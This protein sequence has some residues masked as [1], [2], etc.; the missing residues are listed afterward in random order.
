MGVLTF[1][2]MF[3]WFLTHKLLL[4]SRILI[5]KHRPR[6][7]RNSGI[8]VFLLSL[9]G[10]LQQC[11]EWSQCRGK[12][13]CDLWL[14]VLHCV[15]SVG[16]RSPNLSTGSGLTWSAQWQESNTQADLIWQRETRADLAP[17]SY[18]AWPG[19]H[20]GNSREA[21][22]GWNNNRDLSTTSETRCG[23]TSVRHGHG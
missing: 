5:L 6:T 8:I 20:H 22:L 18:R 9:N 16:S 17:L 1:V 10:Q 19:G 2:F 4:P 13:H 21:S 3:S 14:P 15:T 12:A 7:K 23:R 11:E